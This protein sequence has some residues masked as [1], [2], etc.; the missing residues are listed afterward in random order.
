MRRFLFWKITLS[1]GH[2]PTIEL[3][4]KYHLMQFAEVTRAVR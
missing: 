3:L 1:Q 4:R 2:M